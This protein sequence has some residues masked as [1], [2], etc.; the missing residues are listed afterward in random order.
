MSRCSSCGAEIMWS[1]TEN[2]KAIPVNPEP[3]LGGNVILECSGSLARVVTP[4]PGVKLYVSHFTTCPHARE[5]RK[6][7]R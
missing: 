1:R 4:N 3:V 6:V 7:K 5:H 2:N